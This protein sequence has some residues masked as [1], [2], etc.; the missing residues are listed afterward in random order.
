[1][2]ALAPC[3]SQIDLSNLALGRVST[4]RLD[5]LASHVTDCRKCADVL[6]RLPHEDPLLAAVRR[7]GQLER[8]LDTLDPKLKTVVE[9]VVSHCQEV[10][11][12]AAAKAARSR[13]E[14]VVQEIKPYLTQ[15]TTDDA[16]GCLQDYRLLR[17]LGVGGMGVVFEAES[18][19]L[20]RRV[21]L[22]ALHPQVVNSP[23]RRARF[24]REARAAARLSGH[25]HVV[26]IHLVSEQGGLP[27]I[28]MPLLRGQSL[29]ERLD[30]Q[31]PL[32]VAEGVQLGR[33]IA[34][35]LAAAHAANL[36]HR[37]LKPANVWIEESGRAKLLDF[38]L[39]QTELPGELTESGMILGTPDYMSPE[40]FDRTTV[41]A[42][43]DLFSLG[44]ILFEAFT[45][46]LAF[47]GE[48]LSQKMLARMQQLPPPVNTLN[49]QVPLAVSLLVVK[50]LARKPEDRPASACEVARELQEVSL[51]PLK[52]SSPVAAA[53]PQSAGRSWSQLA[54]GIGI[55]LSLGAVLLAAAAWQLAD[56]TPP[57]SQQLKPVEL[58]RSKDGALPPLA[59]LSTVAKP[60][61]LPKDSAEVLSWSLESRLHRGGLTRAD[62]SPQSDRVATCDQ[63]G[64]VRI[65]DVATGALQLLLLSSAHPAQD[66]SPT[67]SPDGSVLAMTNYLRQVQLWDTRTGR[68][69]QGWTL[70]ADQQSGPL[71]WS[72]D[73]SQL[74][75][76]GER[77]IQIWNVATRELVNTLQPPE[78][79]LSYAALGWS[80][81]GTTLAAYLITQGRR[82]LHLWELAKSQRTHVVP[83]K[84]S[85]GFPVRWSR[86]SR[87][88]T[89]GAESG[90]FQ[91][92][93]VATGAVAVER[94][95]SSDILLLPGQ[96]NL[97][98]EIVASDKLESIST[99]AEVARK[100]KEYPRVWSPT[101][102]HFVTH[103]TPP[104]LIATA[105]EKVIVELAAADGA[106]AGR[107]SWSASGRVVV[108]DGAVWDLTTGRLLRSVPFEGVYGPV[109]GPLGK[110]VFCVRGAQALVIDLDDG[111]EQFINWDRREVIGW[112]PDEKH[113]VS[114]QNGKLLRLDLA[115]KATLEFQ[116]D[117]AGAA[118]VSLVWSPTGD[119]VAGIARRV[120]DNV[121]SFQL[122]L[123]NGLTGEQLGEP[124]AQ[125]YR[126]YWSPDGKWLLA[127]D[128]PSPTGRLSLLNPLGELITTY[129]IS[130]ENANWSDFGFSNDS[131]QVIVGTSD[132]WRVF[133]RE[134][135]KILPEQSVPVKYGG[136]L[137]P[138]GRHLIMLG[139]WLLDLRTREFNCQL[140][141]LQNGLGVMVAADGHFR[142]SGLNQ[143]RYVV[144][145]PSQQLLLN[146]GEFESRFGWKNDP[147]RVTPL[148]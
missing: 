6:E 24:L 133:D 112:S 14:N 137:S 94:A 122:R 5:P 78:K 134:T 19:S 107:V 62:F 126:V 55:V 37:D 8:D 51:Q 142:G 48:T 80:P 9:R 101:G 57:I 71:A 68:A 103:S 135:G 143:L 117:L 67:W 49:P 138:D 17:V 39:A 66:S 35:G 13:L 109:V 132:Q 4:D 10:R 89:M 29:H 45:G 121:E 31:P 38:G 148:P 92:I 145:F 87:H 60:G 93:D 82:E 125:Y 76:A 88:V 81:D 115:T 99:V 59:S 21:A 69:L 124:A 11:Q 111:R 53:R 120:Q 118:L 23:D 141:P 34:A 65:W 73:G 136:S 127:L 46:K 15:R 72:P 91:V 33:D 25:D 22:K 128:S 1:M 74:A 63:L 44:C 61:P 16:I 58:V 147:Q 40:Q 123:W 102:Q 86:D 56:R 52:K 30:A 119:V 116:G 77:D 20:Q 105:S 75:T 32:S 114:F 12:S 27:F 18:I 113:L 2:N 96:T 139:A 83:S 42:R 110:K 7:V 146:P 97:G 84:N 43:S 79:Q 100:L 64:T 95:G 54:G 129:A 28:V 70:A 104:Q 50:L 140:L 106:A 36:V 3:P 41:D 130:A 26:E 144:Q 98:P 85:S 47:G 131:R 90:V 108:I